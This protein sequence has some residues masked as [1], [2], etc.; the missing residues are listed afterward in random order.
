LTSMATAG[1]MSFYI[2]GTPAENFTTVEASSTL[3]YNFSA[4]L[5]GTLN[6]TYTEFLGN[7]PGVSAT[8]NMVMIGLTKTFK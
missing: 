2:P 8:Q 6:Y 3:S 7:I 1:P 4:T 5:I